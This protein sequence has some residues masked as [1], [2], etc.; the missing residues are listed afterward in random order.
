MTKVI[1]DTGPLVALLNRREAQHS[2][3]KARLAEIEPPLL[4]CEAVLSEVCFL[5]RGVHGGQTA[6]MATLSS[7]LVRPA[8]SLAE[9]SEAVT[10]LVTRFS[11]MPMSLADACIVRMLE[12]SDSSVLT[13]ESDFLIYRKNR[14]EPIPVILPER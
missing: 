14:N 6:V 11:S 2:W 12:V 1:L 4:T 7:G 8:F 10:E 13:F 9:H 5:L 3:V